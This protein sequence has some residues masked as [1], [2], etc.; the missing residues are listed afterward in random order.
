M[1][2]Y[3]FETSL[4]DPLVIELGDKVY[5]SVPRSVRLIQDMEDLKKKYEAGM[6][7][8]LDLMVQI[9]GLVFGLN[10]DEFRTIDRSYLEAFTEKATGYI[11]E[12][13]GKPANFT[14]PTVPP[15][16]KEESEKNV[17]TPGSEIT[18]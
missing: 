13:K 17:L 3:I 1:P 9:L 15:A 11:G 8:E 12:G 2:R 18:P 16:Q 5:T 14:D 4:F 7:S 10:P 6:V